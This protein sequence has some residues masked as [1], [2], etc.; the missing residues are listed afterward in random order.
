MENLTIKQKLKVL[1]YIRKELLRINNLKNP[2]CDFI[3]IEFR[4]I[5]K[6]NEFNFLNYYISNVFPELVTEIRRV[7]ILHNP[8]YVFPNQL[9]FKDE[10]GEIVE[11]N[12]LSGEKAIWYNKIKLDMVSRVRKQLTKGKY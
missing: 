6:Y 11:T 7:G 4:K 9:C 10:S 8:D 1:S 12:N 3:C 5:I 2:Y